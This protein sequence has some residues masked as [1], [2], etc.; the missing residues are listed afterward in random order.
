MIYEICCQIINYIYC[1]ISHKFSLSVR[2]NTNVY[3]IKL[4]QIRANIQTQVIDTQNNANISIVN[5]LRIQ[6]NTS[7]RQSIRV[8]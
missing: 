6:I 8:N 3:V 5:R 1:N 2:V 7:I 4:I